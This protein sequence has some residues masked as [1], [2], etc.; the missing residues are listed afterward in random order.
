M[1]RHSAGNSAFPRN[2]SLRPA[3]TGISVRCASS[4]S[5]AMLRVPAPGCAN[6]FTT[7]TASTRMPG[8]VSRN[9]MAIKSSEPA[10]VSIRMGAGCPSA[11]VAAATKTALSKHVR[12]SI[13]TCQHSSARPQLLSLGAQR[14]WIHHHT[15]FRSLEDLMQDLIGRQLAFEIIYAI[16]ADDEARAIVL[17]DEPLGAQVPQC[18]QEP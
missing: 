14:L 17:Q 2:G 10:S 3:N 12:G 16:G 13:R 15:H 8:C 9:A 1:R 4:S 11:A 6:P 7:V 5:R 18:E